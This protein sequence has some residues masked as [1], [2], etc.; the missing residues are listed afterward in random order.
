MPVA[1]PHPVQEERHARH[2]LHP[3]HEDDLG[4]AER[5]LLRA[6]LG[7]LHA[8][9]AGDVDV[10]GADLLRHAGP[11]RD[12]TAG[13]RAVAG[14][15]RVAEDRLVDLIRRRPPPGAAPRRR[16][17]CRARPRACRRTTPGTCRWA[18]GRPRGSP[19]APWPRVY[20]RSRRGR[21]DGAAPAART[22]ASTRAISR[23]PAT[24]SA[25]GTSTRSMRRSRRRGD[26]RSHGG[27]LVGAIARAGEG[28]R[29]GPVAAAHGRPRQ[30]DP[31]AV[32]RHQDHR[33][34]R[35]RATPPAVTAAGSRRGRGAGP[36]RVPPPRS[37]PAR[38]GTTCVRRALRGARPASAGRSGGAGRA[39]RSVRG[40]YGRRRARRTG[41]C[42]RARTAR[43]GCGPASRWCTGGSARPPRGPPWRAAP[44]RSSRRGRG[45]PRRRIV[46]RAR[47]S[48]A[49][50]PPRG[51]ASGTRSGA[52]SSRGGCTGA[53]GRRSAGPPARAPRARTR[54][55]RRR[56][57]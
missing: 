15:P 49:G 23:P 29:A 10:V 42:R 32:G 4:V 35:P 16:R 43:S 56:P 48:T 25:G 8:R 53:R 12:L 54:S 36:G 17:G 11:D 44:G 38:R 21:P 34:R 41:P 7:R 3:A 39:L 57:R 26:P 55:A 2:V 51:R 24:G 27:E 1:E 46:R 31:G 18:S 52:R 47:P 20:R 9:A 37:A 5:D 13:V 22:A 14:L 6:E 19:R 33:A 45:T 28:D 50:R 30:R 40:R